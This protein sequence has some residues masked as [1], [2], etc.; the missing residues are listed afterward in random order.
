MTTMTM[1]YNRPNAFAAKVLN[2]LMMGLTRL[3]VSMRGAHVLWTK[4]RKT[5]EWRKTPVNPMEWGGERYLIAPR[6]NTHWARNLQA[7]PS[8][9]LQVGRR[10]ED[11]TVEEVPVEQRPVLLR[12][13]L[14]RWA[15]ETAKQ[16]GVG[17]DVSE[18]ALAGIALEHPVFRIRG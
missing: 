9:R 12:A 3:G 5:G 4:G 18:E 11:I 15:M 7:A 6:G 1:H 13:Y 14:D 10:T 17:K 2:P 8:G 16:F